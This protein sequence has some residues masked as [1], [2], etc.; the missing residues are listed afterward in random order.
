M[1]FIIHWTVVSLASVNHQIIPIPILSSEVFEKHQDYILLNLITQ[2]SQ[3]YIFSK[4]CKCR[5]K[6]QELLCSREVSQTIIEVGC[7]TCIV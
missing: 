3:N 6:A 4:W 7:K 2:L 1:T 5:T